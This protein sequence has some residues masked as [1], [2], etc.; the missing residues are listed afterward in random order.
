AVHVPRFNTS[1][2]KTTTPNAIRAQPPRSNRFGTGQPDS[3]GASPPGPTSRMC[4]L[5]YTHRSAATTGRPGGGLAG[6]ALDPA[7]EP[8]AAVGRGRYLIGLPRSQVEG[9]ARP[10]DVAIALDQVEVLG[11]AEDRDRQARRI[12]AGLGDELLEIR[13]EPKHVAVLG[14]PRGRAPPRALG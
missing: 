3:A 9:Q 8:G 13:Q 5:R 7:H 14:P 12:A 6:S 1:T 4:A 2:S 11:D 10:T